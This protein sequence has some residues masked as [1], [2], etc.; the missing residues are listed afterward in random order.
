MVCLHI[1]FFIL[2]IW[3]FNLLLLYT[4]S[5]VLRTLKRKKSFTSQIMR[6]YPN[7]NID[8]S[9]SYIIIT[10]NCLCHRRQVESERASEMRDDR[11][12]FE[13]HK[14]PHYLTFY[15]SSSLPLFGIEITTTKNTR[16]SS[17]LHQDIPSNRVERNWKAKNYTWQEL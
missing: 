16:T 13:C 17:W 6:R 8:P 11:K 3:L 12:A 7:M 4:M 2:F 9:S 1:F 10:M 14:W 5:C 15:V